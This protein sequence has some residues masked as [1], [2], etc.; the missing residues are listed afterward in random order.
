MQ[1]ERI[2]KFLSRAGVCSRRDGERL[3]LEGRVKLNGTLLET[4]ATLVDANDTIEVDG[5][6]IGKKSKTRVWIYYK[7][8]GV[9]TTHKDPEGRRT[10]FEEL[11]TSM[12]R[13]MS[14]GRLDLNSEGLLVL[15]NDGEFVRHAEHPSTGWKRTY[16][17]RVQGIVDAHALKELRN[18]ILIEGMHY[19][20]VDAQLLRQ[21]GNNAW[22]LMTLSEGKNREIR[23]IMTHLGYRVNRLIRLAYGPFELGD[24]LPGDLQEVFE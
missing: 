10:V 23:R 19:K 16:K 17:V 5:K 1:K 6:I 2:A 7:P 14:V 3:I 11:P 4:P 24:M 12:P 13:V 15:T 9:M 21:T 8:A 18:G 20:S 22:I